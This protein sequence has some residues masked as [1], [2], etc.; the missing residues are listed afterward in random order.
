MKLSQKRIL[1]VFAAAAMTVCAVPQS[2]PLSLMQPVLTASAEGSVLDDLTWDQIGDGTGIIITGYNGKDTTLAIPDTIDDLPVTAIKSWAFSGKNTLVSVSLPDSI[3][4]I[5]NN[6]F[7]QCKNL[8]TINMPESLKTIG[9]TA[10]G[11]CEA[12][13]KIDLPVGVTS[14]GTGA[15]SSCT[16][17]ASVTIPETVT[18]IGE[19]AFRGTAWLTAKREENPLVIIN[20]ILIDGATCSGDVVFPDDVTVTSICGQAFCSEI[21]VLV[22]DNWISG[23]TTMTSI[24]IPDSVVSIGNNAFDNC[25]A[26]KTVTLQD[27]LKSI[28]SKAFY[29]CPE[30]TAITIPD[31]V[32]EI[33]NSVFFGCKK[34]A[35]V[36]LSAGLTEIPNSN[37]EGFFQGC[38]MKEIEIPE[39]ITTIGML[40]FAQCESLEKVTVPRSVTSIRNA[41]FYGCSSLT[42]IRGYAGSTAETYAKQ[43]DYTFEAIEAE[44]S[45]V[46]LTLTDDLALNFYVTEVNAENKD[47]Y[48]VVFSGKCEEKGKDTAITEKKGRYCAAANVSADHMGETITASLYKKTDDAWEKIDTCKYSVNQYLDNAA[49]EA[50]WSDVKAEA[51]D[52]LVDTV[53]LYG[54]VSYAYFNTPDDMPEVT[55]HRNEIHKSDYNRYLKYDARTSENCLDTLDTDKCSLVLNSKLSLRW[56]LDGLTEGETG[57]LQFG[58]KP[59]LTAKNG[60]YGC[61]FELSGY[62]PLELNSVYEI[63]YNGYHYQFSPLTWA[64]RVFDEDDIIRSDVAMANILFEYY[65]DATAFYNAN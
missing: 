33:G 39:G 7:S 11:S 8:K 42:T 45:D 64:Y 62:T 29:N 20:H 53:R 46:S 51:F 3:T 18:S 35:D 14:I 9:D 24:T 43:N 5:Q 48:K 13:E 37:R 40:A 50:D 63:E 28:G 57:T 6:A 21:K 17:L 47:D 52:K 61:Y 55:N 58:E 65:T 27:G 54:K 10:F 4:E 2:A 44:F 32:T 41:A 26:L 16:A 34:L 22:D 49:P 59:T 23:N 38:A 12:L 15:F 60:K 36:Q 30:L 19:T 25:K 1:S 56:Y 31:S